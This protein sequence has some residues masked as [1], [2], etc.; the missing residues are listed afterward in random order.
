[1]STDTQALQ[2]Q[3][4]AKLAA[5]DHEFAASR[6]DQTVSDAI[7][8]AG[9]HLPAVVEAVLQGYSDRPALAQRAYELVTDPQTG[10]TT[11][12]LLPWFDKVTYGE[13]AD[14][15]G[16]VSRALTDG[17]ITTGDRVCILGFTSVDYTTIDIALG[18]AGAVSVPL[19]TSAAI[20][21][22]LPIVTETE[23]TVFAASIDYL[24]DAVD[25]ILAGAEAA[26]L[27]DGWWC[28]TTAASSTTTVTRCRAR[29]SGWPTSS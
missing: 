4:A 8:A 18:V 16:K 29:G 19:Q 1:M 23:P 25:V 15:V 22:L 27:P 20:T 6:P 13:L 11:A 5:A 2:E 28:S 26:T 7:V 24:S 12:K 21:Q 17:L 14:R 10:R 9:P 3:R